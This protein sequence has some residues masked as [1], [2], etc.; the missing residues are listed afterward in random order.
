MYGSA[1]FATQTV[2]YEKTAT[3]P[4]LMPTASG[5]WDVDF[6]LPVTTDTL[7]YWVTE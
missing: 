5:H 4:Q 2:D 1:V 7:V 3:E 6:N